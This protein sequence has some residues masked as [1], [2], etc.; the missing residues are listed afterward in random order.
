MWNL[1]SYLAHI[2][3]EAKKRFLVQIK[4]NLSEETKNKYKTKKIVLKQSS[5]TDVDNSIKILSKENDLPSNSIKNLYLDCVENNK[6]R[7]KLFKIPDGVLE[8]F[9][10]D[11]CIDIKGRNYL[12]NLYSNSE[13]I[14]R[15]TQNGFFLTYIRQVNENEVRFVY[16]WAYTYTKRNKDGQ[17]VDAN[18]VIPACI[19]INTETGFAQIRICT[20][21]GVQYSELW[22]E[23]NTQL[24][25]ILQSERLRKYSLT[26]TINYLFNNQ[27][28]TKFEGRH[29]YV[30]NLANKSSCN[31]AIT[32]RVDSTAKNIDYVNLPIFDIIRRQKY[33]GAIEVIK[34]YWNLEDVNV[35]NAFETTNKAIHFDAVN[36]EIHLKSNY[37][38]NEVQ[39][40]LSKIQ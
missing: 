32:I 8:D 38:E 6:M 36:Q 20:A 15:F 4:E 40:V 29:K 27:I 16:R 2:N 22:E 12:S 18:N 30:Q 28:L 7:I 9:S 26:N 11:A 3:L 24:I 35:K 23:L 17:I 39:Y 34:G 19:V 1:D 10:F 33:E 21:T 14:S 37:M 13:K 31:A 25:E 5:A